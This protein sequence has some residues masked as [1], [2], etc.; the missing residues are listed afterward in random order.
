MQNLLGSSPQAKLGYALMALGVLKATEHL[1]GL[2]RG[3]WKH[4]LR[5]RRRLKARYGR[6]DMDPWVLISGKLPYHQPLPIRYQIVPEK[7]L[8][9]IKSLKMTFL[10]MPN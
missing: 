6:Q 5:P 3:T 4:L 2:V 10:P 9:N 7:I 8:G 1:A